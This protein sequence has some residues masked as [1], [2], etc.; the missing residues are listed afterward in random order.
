MMVVAGYHAHWRDLIS[1][2]LGGMAER[3]NA[4]VLK[5]SV[6][7]A[8][9]GSNPSPSA[10]DRAIKTQPS[11]SSPTRYEPNTLTRAR[12]W[13]RPFRHSETFVSSM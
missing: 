1:S 2:S 6:V 4:L 7:K 12:C 13:V 3:T 11:R 5:T 9:E 10:N 8:T